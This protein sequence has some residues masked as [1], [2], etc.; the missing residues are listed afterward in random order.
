MFTEHSRTELIPHRNTFYAESS[1]ALPVTVP[2]PILATTA[3]ESTQ[4]P[5]LTT[6]AEITP[7]PEPDARMTEG[8]FTADGNEGSLW[9]TTDISDEEDLSAVNESET[10]GKTLT[11]AYYIIIGLGVVI[12]II[13]VIV[14]V[15][16]I[17]Y[18]CRKSRNM[19]KGRGVF[20]AVID[21]YRRTPKSKLWPIYS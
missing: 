15:A 7:W 13:V 21:S 17:A 18:K 3:E 14:V 8:A 4:P 20:H 12:L 1:P 5:P 16:V 10:G 6:R 9:P 19:H 11:R 2:N